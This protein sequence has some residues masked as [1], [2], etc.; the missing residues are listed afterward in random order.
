M[1]EAVLNSGGKEFVRK[2]GLAANVKKVGLTNL[3]KDE[4]SEKI[5][6]LTKYKQFTAT[7]SRNVNRNSRLISPNGQ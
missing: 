7:F 1:C 3:F 4:F 5:L 6:W 2:S